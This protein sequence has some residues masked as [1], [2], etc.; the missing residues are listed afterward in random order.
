M[1]RTDLIKKTIERLSNLPQDVAVV[2][3]YKGK[4]YSIVP[5]YLNNPVM[6]KNLTMNEIKPILFGEIVEEQQELCKSNPR[7]QFFTFRAE[8]GI[9]VWSLAYKCSKNDEQ[10]EFFSFELADGHIWEGYYGKIFAPAQMT[11]IEVKLL[12]WEIAEKYKISDVH[13][14][15]Q[16]LDYPIFEG[17]RDRCSPNPF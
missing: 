16:S 5:E 8:A 13:V 3:N 11:L 15:I 10:I 4:K 7:Y 9:D 2:V 12:M 6:L 1:K 14:L 17:L